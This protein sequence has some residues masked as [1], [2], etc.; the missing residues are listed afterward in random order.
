M[1]QKKAPAKKPTNLGLGSL[2]G[3]ANSTTRTRRIDS[4]LEDV[5]G[6]KPKDKS[7]PKKK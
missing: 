7:K 2:R 3:A 4:Y 1:A 6:E 5:T